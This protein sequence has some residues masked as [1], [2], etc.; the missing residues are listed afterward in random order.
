MSLFSSRKDKAQA[1]NRESRWLEVIA[2]VLP[3]G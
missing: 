1:P 3:K 2:F